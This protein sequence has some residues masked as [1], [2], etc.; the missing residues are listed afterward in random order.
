MITSSIAS[1]K[2]TFESE[3]K[4]LHTKVSDLTEHVYKLESARVEPQNST[5]SSNSIDLTI[6]QPH[7]SLSSLPEITS[8]VMTI[9]NEEKAKEKRKLNIIIHGVQ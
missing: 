7:S 6:S 5:P 1:L 9:L 3:V 8:S 2:A 4:S